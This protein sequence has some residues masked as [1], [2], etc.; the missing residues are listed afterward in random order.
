[1][2]EE[3]NNIPETKFSFVSSES[4]EDLLRANLEKN[5]EILDIAR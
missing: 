5:N 2:I 4:L 1:M 3:K